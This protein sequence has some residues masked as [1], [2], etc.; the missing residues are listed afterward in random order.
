[1]RAVIIVILTLFLLLPAHADDSAFCEDPK[2]W[3][4]F[5]SLTKK[6][7]NDIPLQLLHALKIGLCVKVEKNS[8]RLDE[9]IQIFNDMVD[10]VVNKRDEDQD[11]QEL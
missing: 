2:M 6:M 9:A 4:Y 10:T 8:I 3:A 5:D 1:M 11:S 7:P